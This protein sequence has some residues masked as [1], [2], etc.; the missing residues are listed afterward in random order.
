MGGGVF[1]GKG[2]GWVCSPRDVMRILEQDRRY[3]SSGSYMRN[4]V[5]HLRCCIGERKSLP[6]SLRCS[7]AE[8][9]L[10]M[11]NANEGGTYGNGL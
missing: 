5:L 8:K 6:S 10:R 2:I 9:V 4:L 3:S 1:V 11:K 7:Q